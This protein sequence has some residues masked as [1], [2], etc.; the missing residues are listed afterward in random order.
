MIFPDEDEIRIQKAGNNDLNEIGCLEKVSFE[1]DAFSKRQ[2]WYLLNKA[3]GV[4][5]LA[6]QG[7]KTLGYLILLS[8]KNSR[9]IRIYSIAV[10]TE[11]RGVGIGK[12][13]LDY[14]EKEARKTGKSRI[15]LEVSERNKSA[16]QLY[17]KFG[18]QK[19]GEK[20]NYYADG[21]NAHIMI[22]E[23]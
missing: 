22:K 7:S 9:Q 17:K 2:F 19:K 8:R 1:G 20:T 12:K 10:A 3:N 15:T 5:V 6:K 11:A 23:I 14:T 16:I 18:Y 21:S 4:F 13:L